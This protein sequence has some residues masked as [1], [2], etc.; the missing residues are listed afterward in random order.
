MFGFVISFDAP[1]GSYPITCPKERLAHTLG[2]ARRLASPRRPFLLMIRCLQIGKPTIELGCPMP[3]V[4]ARARPPHFL[5]ERAGPAASSP[6]QFPATER[7][8]KLALRAGGC[9]QRLGCLER[10]GL[11]PD[12]DDATGRG[13]SAVG[14]LKNAALRGLGWA[15]SPSYLSVSVSFS[16]HSLGQR[17]DIAVSCSG[18]L[19]LGPSR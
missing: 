3:R 14:G 19:I 16:L 11:G 7:L 17:C 10:L 4:N 8:R 13:T 9:R 2:A 18:R 5:A 1:L 6:P 12:S 15:L